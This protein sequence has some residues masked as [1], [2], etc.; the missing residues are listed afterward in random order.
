MAPSAPRPGST[1][2]VARRLGPAASEREPPSAAPPP[3]SASA[4]S[5]VTPEAPTRPPAREPA[6][7]ALGARV[8]DAYLALAVLAY[9][10]VYAV[11]FLSL[12]QF[13]GPFELGQASQGLMP[14]A[15]ILAAPAA[16]SGGAVVELLRRAAGARAR[17]AA[18]LL[19]GVLGGVVGW[20]VAGGRHFQGGLRVPFAAVLATAAGAAAFA[21]APRV[22][23]LLVA[24]RG[25]GRAAVFLGVILAAL[26]AVDATNVRV[27]PRLYPAFHL[28]LSGV[29]L[30]LGA[31][32]GLAWGAV[33]A[34]NRAGSLLAGPLLRAAVAAVVFAL[35]AAR[36]PAA[37][38]RLARLD[39]VRIIYLERAPLLA[40]VVAVA[41][42]LSP[43]APIEDT[44]LEEPRAAGHAVD[45]AGRD[46]LL[47]TVDALRADHVGAYG[48]ARPTTP[49]L[50]ALAAE[51]VVFDAA[52]SPTPHTSYA[53]T[54]IM[55]G[56]YMRPLVLQGLGDDSE[57]WAGD[58]RRYGYRT[59]AF[60]P[61]AVFFIDAERFG[62]FR[63][64][65]LDFEYRRVEFAPR[66]PAPPR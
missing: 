2:G 27:L 42:E 45:L 14:V 34:P 19:A 9:L 17:A 7:L 59:A 37:A 36:A 46:L 29:A 6:I 10:E 30:L 4:R 63:D 51:G 22:A 13:V 24:P 64:R 44:A 15:L 47:I 8:A 26:V 12:K 55:T 18:A 16:L 58:L 23:R 20:G 43:P 25:L 35:G 66:P 5:E 49:H 3:P 28:A 50:D 61:P 31:A 62:A 11:G 52:Y 40:H 39:N 33:D 41:A 54:S 53:V 65:A 48:Y 60:Y 56:K 32:A 57:T 38:K 1:P 21:I